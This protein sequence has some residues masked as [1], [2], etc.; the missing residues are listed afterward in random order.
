M[1]DSNTSEF[2]YPAEAE[3]K[4]QYL[5][6][7]EHSVLLPID[8][9]LASKIGLVITHWGFFEDRINALIEHLLPAAEVEERNWQ[10]RSFERRRK[11]LRELLKAVG[12]AQNDEVG[13]VGLAQVLEASSKL[14]W[15]RN[16]ITHGTYRAIIGPNS[17]NANWRAIGFHNGETVTVPLDPETLDWLRHEIG[18]LTGKLLQTINLVGTSEGGWPIVSDTQLLQQLREHDERNAPSR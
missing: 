1:P 10:W 14:Q 2:P 4:R 16:I 9:G 6:E 8:A 11:L 12:F 3:L 5:R 7:G 17:S 13:Q 18:H 15:R